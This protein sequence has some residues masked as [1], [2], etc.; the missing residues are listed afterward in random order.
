VSRANPL[1]ERFLGVK[2]CR[3][4]A[5]PGNVVVTVVLLAVAPGGSY[6][7]TAAATLSHAWT[8]THGKPLSFEE[9]CCYVLGEVERAH[10]G[11]DPVRDSPLSRAQHRRLHHRSPAARA[12]PLACPGGAPAGD[13]WPPPVPED[14]LELFHACTGR[15]R[16]PTGGFSEVA[17]IAGAR[18]GKDSRIAAPIVVFE[19]VFGGHERH[20]ARGE[21]GVIPLVAQDARAAKI[22]YGYVRDYLT[23]SPMLSALVDDVL[24]SEIILTNSLAIAIFPSTLRS[25]RGWSI[26]AGVL[27]ELA[28]FRL[29]GAADSDVEIQASIRR[30]MVSF[31]RTKL[32]KISTPYMK[33]GVLYDD[34]RR[35]FGQDDPDLLVWKASSL[36]MNPSLTSDRLDRERRIDPSRFA[37]EYEAEF[38]DDL[39]S[40]LPGAWVDQAV[41]PGRH[42]LPP[43]DGVRYLGAVDPSGGGA[44]A[45]TVAIVHVE[46]D[47]AQRRVVQDVMKGWQRRGADAANLEGV[48]AE[49]VSLCRRYQLHHVVGD[50]YGSQWV[51]E[52]FRR[53]GLQYRDAEL[54][55]DGEMKYLDKSAAYAEVEPVFAQGRVEILDH[56]Q[57]VRELKLLERRPRVGGKAIIDHPHGGHDDHAN[58]LALAVALA[59][60]GRLRPFAGPVLPRGIA[61]GVPSTLG[62]VGAVRQPVR[63]HAGGVGG[64]ARYLSRWYG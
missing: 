39:E 25:L 40:F 19:A 57:L 45:F 43:L 54:R 21:R 55:V 64:Q 8:A 37:R 32:V 20:L 26:P 31:P 24:A 15:Q 47:G 5:P 58:A 10:Y 23:R 29:E 59:A 42:E 11:H 22:A 6:V 50:R 38:A 46:G 36:L 48:V 7:V 16:P 51:R 3:Y 1:F 28:F 2:T 60:Q 33:S 14:H 41:I 13:L 12:Q 56:P 34:F 52:A 61:L 30:G 44:D 4:P 63:R 49:I 27:D 53:A 62:V 17:V 18:A 35:G 9:A